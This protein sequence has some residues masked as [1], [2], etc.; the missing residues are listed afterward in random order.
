MPRA[1]TGRRLKATAL[2]LGRSDHYDQKEGGPNRASRFGPPGWKAYTFPL[3]TTLPL[4]MTLP[5]RQ[6]NVAPE[7]A[8][9]EPSPGRGRVGRWSG[10]C[11]QLILGHRQLELHVI[12]VGGRHHMEGG[13]HERHVLL[14]D[15]EEPANSNDIGEN[16]AVLVEQDVRNV[17]NLL[18]VGADHVG[19]F[20]LGRQH[21]IGFLLRDEFAG[22]LGTRRRRR[23]ARRR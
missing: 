14:A 4:R 8:K 20:Q 9:L 1:N 7:A 12:F 3:L 15:A 2:L 16:L 11:L 22:G 18:V 13:W 6:F 23:G 17:A 21:L 5:V 19:A 10:R